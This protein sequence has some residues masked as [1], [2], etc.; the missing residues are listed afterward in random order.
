MR[1]TGESGE[2]R[3]GHRHAAVLGRWTIEPAGRSFVLR[4][5]VASEDAFWV[6]ER[7]LDVLLDVGGTRWL[8]RHA[9]VELGGGEVVARISEL[10][11][12]EMRS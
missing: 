10:P 9:N 11:I 6:N 12:V 8:W 2:L 4:A 5:S 7:P 1:A 3:V